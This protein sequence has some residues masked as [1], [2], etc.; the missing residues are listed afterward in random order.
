MHLQLSLFFLK[1]APGEIP[2]SAD[3]WEVN[4]TR[5]IELLSRKACTMV[6]TRWTVAACANFEALSSRTG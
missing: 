3:K 4:T 5:A 2:S 6:Q 1:S